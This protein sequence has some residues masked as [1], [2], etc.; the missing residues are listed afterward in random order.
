[1]TAGARLRRRGI[2]EQNNVRG[3]KSELGTGEQIGHGLRVVHRAVEILKRA[4]FA[5]AVDAAG[6]M[7]CSCACG[8]ISVDADEEGALRL[9]RR[10]R[11]DN[12]ANQHTRTDEVRFHKRS[13]DTNAF[14]GDPPIATRVNAA[15]KI[16]PRGLC[17]LNPNHHLVWLP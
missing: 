8:L 9:S 4:E 14:L 7:I 12:R 3:R 1:M 17:N 6:G 16:P 10:N 5:A 15:P 2:G 13:R 11:T